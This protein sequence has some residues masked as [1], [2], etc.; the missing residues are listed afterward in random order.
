MGACYEGGD[1]GYEGVV[2][3]GGEKTGR[4]TDR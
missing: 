2:G 4:R 3:R 1:G